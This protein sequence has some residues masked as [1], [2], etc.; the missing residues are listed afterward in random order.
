MSFLANRLSSIKPSP[1]ISINT[2]SQELKAQGRD[3]IGLAAGEPDFDT[4]QNI[5]DAAVRAMAE[6]KTKY[7]P[8]AGIPPLRE[9]ICEYAA[10]EWGARYPVESV[11]I[12][13]GARPILYGAYRCVVNPGDKVVYPVPSWNNNHYVW[14]TGAQ[15]VAVPTRSEEIGRA[16]V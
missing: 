2:L 13:S 5:K 6:G 15:G 10:R 1:T 9:A 7:A 4:P 12:A 8:P 3:V 14:M 16:H 11:L